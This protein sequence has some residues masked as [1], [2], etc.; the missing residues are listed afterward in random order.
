MVDEI[1]RT[2]AQEWRD[3]VVVIV[4][5]HRVTP[6][7]LGELEHPSGADDS[8][9]PD[10]QQASARDLPGHEHA[11][12]LARTAVSDETRGEVMDAA[13]TSTPEG[14]G[15]RAEHQGLRGRAGPGDRAAELYGRPVILAMTSG[16]HGP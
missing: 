12:P 6:S 13:A 7:H 4:D 3:E 5:L 9:S 15:L 8:A 16:P 14:D 11:E 2:D 1:G 10:A